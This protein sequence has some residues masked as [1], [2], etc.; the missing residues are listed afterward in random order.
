MAYNFD[1]YTRIGCWFHLKQNLIRYARIC[2][3]MNNK[4]ID[5]NTTMEIITQLSLLPIEY[6]GDIKFE[7]IN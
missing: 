3:L 1:N 7:K 6:K 5:I 4:N 2:G